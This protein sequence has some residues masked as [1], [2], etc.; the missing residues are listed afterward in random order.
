MKKIYHF[1]RLLIKKIL[2]NIEKRKI[3]YYEK[4]EILRKSKIINSVDISKNQIKD[5]NKYW[6]KY[7]GRK[8]SVSWHKLYTYFNGVFII[9][10]FP[11]I[12]FSTLLEYKLNDRE[13][14][15]FYSNKC[16]ASR[17]Y[18]GIEKLVY[19]KT[20]MY[21]SNFINYDE[22]DNLLSFDEAVKLLELKNDFV[23][24]KSV[25]SSSGKSVKLITLFDLDKSEKARIC[26]ELLTEYEKD[27][28]VQEK[29]IQHPNLSKLYSKSVN[30]IRL[31]TYMVDNKINIAPISFRV[32]CND[33]FV[34]NIHAGGIVVGVNNDGRLLNQAYQLGYTDSKI[35]YEKHPNTKI[36][37]SSI[38][39]PEFQNLKDVGIELH[40]KTPG[41]RMI[42]WDLTIDDNNNIVLIEGNY[43]GQSVWFPQIVNQCSLFGKDTS[44]MLELIKKTK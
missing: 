6:R 44:K 7:Y 2:I 4:L 13:L 39:I 40:K 3:Y 28:I 34:D 27:F 10:Y 29:I 38:E 16:L 8:I 5:F 22:K 21:N 24:K 17:L 26:K 14:S 43:F 19:P 20:I 23:I 1:L 30:T 9:D 32:G 31:I 15:I 41:L 35:I 33:N 25:D 42:S 12:L 36:S 11:D 18:S 37:F